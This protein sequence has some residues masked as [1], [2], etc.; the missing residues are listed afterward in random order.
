MIVTMKPTATAFT[1][2]LRQRSEV[3]GFRV[4]HTQGWY[5][6]P[7]KELSERPLLIGR[8][9]RCDFR[10]RHETISR[11]HCALAMSVDGRILLVDRASK[12]GLRVARRGH[13]GV[14]QTI[15]WHALEVGDLIRLGNIRM[16]VVDD[17]GGCPIQITKCADLVRFAL[18]IFGTEKHACNCLNIPRGVWRNLCQELEINR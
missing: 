7:M 15:K 3:A 4:L 12:N 8:T 6:I 17:H 9:N 11:Q 14:Y 5:R 2:S 10:I 1:H 13:C 18:Q 16:I